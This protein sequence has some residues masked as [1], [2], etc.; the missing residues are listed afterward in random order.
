MEGTSNND[1]PY[2]RASQRIRQRQDAV[3]Q[4]LQ[5]SWKSAHDKLPPDEE[6]DLA[7][8]LL[9]LASAFGSELPR[10]ISLLCGVMP[11]LQEDS[12]FNIASAATGIPAHTLEELQSRKSSIDLGYVGD[13]DQELAI[14]ASEDGASLLR[15]MDTYGSLASIEEIIDAEESADEQV[16]QPWLDG[17]RL[18][19]DQR[20]EDAVSQRDEDAGSR[21]LKNWISPCATPELEISDEEFEKEEDAKEPLADTRSFCSAASIMSS[22]PSSPASCCG[23]SVLRSLIAAG[24]PEISSEDACRRITVFDMTAD[25]SRE[26]TALDTEPN[27]SQ[28]ISHQLTVFDMTNQDSDILLELD[29]ESEEV[30]EDVAELV[31]TFEGAQCMPRTPSTCSGTLISFSPQV[32]GMP[33]TRKDAGS[34]LTSTLELNSSSG[35]VDRLDACEDAETTAGGVRQL[36]GDAVRSLNKD[37]IQ[38]ATEAANERPDQSN[39]H[40]AEVMEEKRAI[41][42]KIELPLPEEKTELPSPQEAKPEKAEVSEVNAAVLELPNEKEVFVS[43]SKATAEAEAK[44]PQREEPAAAG[45][46][47][48]AEEVMETEPEQERDAQAEEAEL[49]LVLMV[50]T[51]L[52]VL[53]EAEPR[54]AEAEEEEI[55]EEAKPQEAAANLEESK[56]TEVPQPQ[57]ATIKEV[58]EVKSK[59]EEAE[60]PQP[61][62]KTPGETKTTEAEEMKEAEFKQPVE[63]QQNGMKAEVEEAQL[64]QPEEATPEEAEAKVEEKSEEELEQPKE[65]KHYP[66]MADLEEAQLAQPEAEA[67]V[68][69]I[70]EAE[71]DEEDETQSEEATSEEAEEVTEPELEQPEKTKHDE[72]KADE[73]EATKVKQVTKP[74]V[75]AQVVEVK[76]KQAE[77]EE[78]QEEV[79]VEQPKEE[80]NTR[81]AEEAKVQEMTKESVVQEVGRVDLAADTLTLAETPSTIVDADTQFQKVKSVMHSTPAK[82]S[83][84]TAELRA[85]FLDSG[86]KERFRYLDAM[87]VRKNSSASDGLAS[88]EELEEPEQATRNLSLEEP[89]SEAPTAEVVVAK[90]EMR[91]DELG[92]DRTVARNASK[93]RMFNRARTNSA[94]NESQSSSKHYPNHRESN[95]AEQ[96]TSLARK[97]R[98]A[99]LGVLSRIG[100]M[101]CGAG[102]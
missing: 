17:L 37:T 4:V 34:S 67:N 31:Q 77:V 12:L 76:E 47:G 98:S 61:E 5:G 7:E 72:P 25:D 79:C 33:S 35:S 93:D 58:E 29:E 24:M 45:A 100:C 32:S 43:D 9:V 75:E 42:E 65:T 56:E 36:F 99:S 20:D 95:S 82:T 73:A 70:N 80:T 90:L 30:A 81:E 92:D 68:E 1:D 85:K 69:W 44:M 19:V 62:E 15:G 89:E 66:T 53:E 51:L 41:E 18:Q 10:R 6:T 83:S 50:P 21:L 59:V 91:L 52:M 84:S 8:T 60:M 39:N 57:Q 94:G 26:L 3:L 101:P 48:E 13:E 49:A 22:C 63:I 78:L 38:Q 23:V 27:D 71:L 28:N 86:V 54:E 102:L 2:T 96:P 55:I 97:P 74:E 40:E 14:G 16:L 64:P 88:N 46:A 11:C 87:V